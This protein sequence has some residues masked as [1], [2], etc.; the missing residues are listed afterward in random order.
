MTV[1]KISEVLRQ[2]MKSA[3]LS[4]RYQAYEAIKA[5]SEVAEEMFG[6]G[7]ARDMKPKYVKNNI[8]YIQ[9]KAPV[10]SSEINLKSRLILDRMEKKTG[11]NKVQ[12]IKCIL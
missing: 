5:F 12:D 11:R 2:R 7:V 10:F 4:E 8:L 9:V 1:K 3:G 6:H